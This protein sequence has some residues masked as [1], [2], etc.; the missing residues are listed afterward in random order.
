MFDKAA[1]GIFCL[2][3]VHLSSGQSTAF[4]ILWPVCL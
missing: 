2:S 4:Q 3:S 1:S